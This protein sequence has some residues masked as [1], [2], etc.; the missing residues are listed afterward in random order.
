MKQIIEGTKE[1]VN[2]LKDGLKIGA[3]EIASPVLE[4]TNKWT[5]RLK[6]NKVTGPAIVVVSKASKPVVSVVSEVVGGIKEGTGELLS[7]LKNNP[8]SK[9]R[10]EASIENSERYKEKC[11]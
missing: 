10:K 6:E 5:D 4:V 7:D 9:G 3:K 2:E 8:F 11:S 1:V